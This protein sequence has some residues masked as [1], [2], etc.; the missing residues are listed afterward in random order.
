MLNL[1][2]A[3]EEVIAKLHYTPKTGTVPIGNVSGGETQQEIDRNMNSLMKQF[4]DLFTNKTGRYKGEPIK[5]QV[6]PNAVPVI[7]P[8][9]RIPLQYRIILLSL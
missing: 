4:P 3:C 7:Q 6:K 8:P 9:R 5:I 1:K 2:G